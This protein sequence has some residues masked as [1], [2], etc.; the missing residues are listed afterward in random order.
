[1]NG[2]C[3]LLVKISFFFASGRLAIS[4]VFFCFGASETKTSREVVTRPLDPTRRSR[5]NSNHLRNSSKK[6]P[7]SEL[8]RGPKCF[9]RSQ[10]AQTGRGEEENGIN[11][12][13]K[14][15]IERWNGRLGKSIRSR[16]VRWFWSVCYF[17][18]AWHEP[19]AGWPIQKRKTCHVLPTTCC[20][21][22]NI[23]Q[24]MASP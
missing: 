24:N 10:T 8:S 4:G 23:D 13:K 17:F 9:V 3:W 18:F 16:H 11:L 15:N 14:G 19:C 20:C 5:D 6:Q 2:L 22:G 7:T 1:M 12:K 21:F